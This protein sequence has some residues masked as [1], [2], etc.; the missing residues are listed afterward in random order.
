MYRLEVEIGRCERLKKH[1]AVLFVDLDGFKPI[2]DVYG[3]K[4]GDTVLQT[5]GQ[6]MSAAVRKTD[7]VARLGGDEFLVILTD[8]EPE[9]APFEVAAKLEA[10]LRQPITLA[11]GTVVA[12]GGS[13][14]ISI[15]PEHGDTADALMASADE[16]MYQVKR[17][18]QQSLIRSG[19]PPRLRVYSGSSGNH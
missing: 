15:Y 17:E 16:A 8:I 12:L 3:H 4:A 5:L 19:T 6:R 14:G 18:N 7:L 11:N 1:F 10:E 13:V 9:K 2:N